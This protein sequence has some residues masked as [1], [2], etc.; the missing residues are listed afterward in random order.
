MGLTL[1]IKVVPG[2]NRQAF[3]LD[4]S[5]IVKCHLKSQPE[6]GK[7]NAELIKLLSK[8]LKIPQDALKIITGATARKKLIKIDGN[9][10]LQHIYNLCGI[11]AQTSIK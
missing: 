5:G 2:S 3:A 8:T 6:H 4:K 1:E 11:E 10:T 9:F 7:A